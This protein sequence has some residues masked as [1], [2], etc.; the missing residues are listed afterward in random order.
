MH[1]NLSRLLLLPSIL[2]VGFF[3]TAL[4]AH[5][6]KRG[7]GLQRAQICAAVSDPAKTRSNGTAISPERQA[8][9]SLLA[10][11]CQLFDAGQRDQIEGLYR[12]VLAS[13]TDPAL[14]RVAYRRLSRMAMRQGNRD[15]AKA[16]RA[17]ARAERCKADSA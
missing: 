3:A 17:Q 14:R 4:H 6:L 12:D 11:E 2:I 5:P 10:Q 8:V 16:L 7:H 13:A 1:M 15:A 9:R